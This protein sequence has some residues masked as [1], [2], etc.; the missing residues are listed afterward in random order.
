M[1]NTWT[2]YNTHYHNSTFPNGTL[3]ISRYC[4]VSRDEQLNQTINCFSIDPN[5]WLYKYLVFVGLVFLWIYWSVR[6]DFQDDTKPKDKD[7]KDKKQDEKEK[8]K[9]KEGEKEKD[10]EGEGKEGEDKDKDYKDKINKDLMNSM[11]SK[12]ASKKL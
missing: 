12:F 10:K 8:E 2:L 7:H 1:N 5:G 3:N 9:D 4:D 11:Q 6:K